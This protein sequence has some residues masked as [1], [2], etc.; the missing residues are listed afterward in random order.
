MLRGTAITK[1]KAFLA[2]YFTNEGTTAVI[3]AEWMVTDTTCKYPPF[4]PS[5]KLVKSRKKEGSEEWETYDCK[6]VAQASKAI[7]I[8]IL[9]YVLICIQ[10][11]LC[12]ESISEVKNAKL[13]DF[14][15]CDFRLITKFCSINAKNAKHKSKNG[16][17][18]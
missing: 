7:K 10:W 14:S 1:M 13:F 2:V 4:D 18:S 3:P 15:W 6:V 8:I 5:T 16:C 17:F 12:Q 9:V 11:F